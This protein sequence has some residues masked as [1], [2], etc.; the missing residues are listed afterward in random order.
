MDEIN[1]ADSLQILWAGLIFMFV[2]SFIAWKVGYYQL[3]TE[4]SEEKLPF[5]VVLI[6]FAIVMLLSM[7]IIPIISL[8]VIYLYKGRIDTT[9]KTILVINYISIMIGLVIVG[10]FQFFLDKTERNLIWGKLF[11]LTTSFNKTITDILIGI[12]TWFIAYPVLIV[13]GRVV[14]LT[15]NYFGLKVP[16]DQV[17]VSHVRS[18][19]TSPLIFYV[20][21]VSMVFFV[22]VIEEFLFRGCLQTWL[23]GKIGIKKAI[24]LTSMIFAS[25][26]FSISQGL[27]NVELLVT[28]FSLSCFLG[29]IYERQQSLL[30]SIALHS[31]FNGVSVFV[32]SIS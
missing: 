14:S 19:L 27:G 2:T 32:I 9:P 15:F 6:S 10:L 26:H 17:A 30:A 16:V 20:V 11:G 22:P 28:L 12:T 3:P 21:A 29:F 13:A 4:T 23:K 7:L 31:F 24:I 18:A 5:R 1:V 25:F 8:F